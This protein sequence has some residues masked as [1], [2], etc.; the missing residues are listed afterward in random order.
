M[1]LHEPVVDAF[2]VLPDRRGAGAG[3]RSGA[4]RWSSCARGADPWVASVRDQM[5]SNQPP[6]R[7]RRSPSYAWLAVALITIVVV[8]VLALLFLGGQVDGIHRTVGNSV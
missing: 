3:R 4:T 2:R 1:P 6:G 8:C 7:T 5:E